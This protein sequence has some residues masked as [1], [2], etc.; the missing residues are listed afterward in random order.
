MLQVTDSPF[1]MLKLFLASGDGDK[2]LTLEDK[3]DKEYNASA[4][5]CTFNNL[6]S[7][8][9]YN[10]YSITFVQILID[11]IKLNMSISV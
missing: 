9:K 11:I 4:F 5:F 6:S 2:T 8:K 3:T 1:D 10:K 7:Y